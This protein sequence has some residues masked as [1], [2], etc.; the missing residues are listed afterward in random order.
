MYEQ[1]AIFPFVRLNL[2]GF[3]NGFAVAIGREMGE[4]EEVDGKFTLSFVVVSHFASL[5][6]IKRHFLFV[7]KDLFLIYIIIF[8]FPSMV[9]I[10]YII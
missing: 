1:N 9:V 2:C 7:C 5:R 6:S 3:V 4:W 10:I 8:N